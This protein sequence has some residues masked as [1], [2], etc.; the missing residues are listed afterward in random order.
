MDTS[1]NSSVD[2]T[3]TFRDYLRVLFRHKAVIAITFITVMVT[4]FI[5]LKLKT[6]VYEAQVKMLISAQKQVEAPY[7]RELGGYGKV[8]MALTQSEI[9]KSNPVIERSVK[10]LRLYGRPLDYEKNFCSPL[11]KRLVDWRTKTLEAKLE[12]LPT[13]QKQTLLFRKAVED[14]KAST[15]VA[16][17]RDTNLFTISVS[18]FSPVGS[19]IT[20][21]VVS[22]SYI[23]FDLEQQLAELQIK[24]GEKH[25]AVKQ[26][27]DNIEK[28]TAN[29]NGEPISAIE[30]IGPASVKIIEQA[31]VPI[32]PTGTPKL[33]TLVLAFFMSW[34]LGVMLAFGFEYMDHTF[35]SPQDVETFLN[36]PLLGSI[37]KKK[38]K[39]KRLVQDAKVITPYTS[40]YQTISDQIQ[41]LIKEK[42]LKSI[43]MTSALEQEGTSTIIANLGIC[44]THKAGCKVLIIDANLRNPSMHTAFKVSNNQGLSDILEGKSSFEEAVKAVDIY[45]IRD[46]S[47]AVRENSCLNV[48]TAGSTGL[49]PITLLDSSK[50]VDVIKKAGK[51]YEIILI[52]CTNL[53]NFRDASAISSL[54]DGIVLVVNE[55]KTRRQVVKSALIPLEKKKANLIGVILNN[56]TFPIPKGIYNRV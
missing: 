15:E 42:N 48:L 39:E 11:K 12:T 31:Q 32:K 40:S 34:F 16:P 9:V 5:G 24:Y 23:I 2:T 43:L 36:L 54:N 22:R 19:A 18:D 28:M 46:N 51:K 47:S 8:E 49:N 20:A 25:L 37:P 53:R 21:N 35:K 3:T 17:I 6:P 50:M 44:L 4:V 33:L 7:Y 52:D 29:L 13:Q 10:A 38:V 45:P 30:A 27:K 56:R 26:L 14:L 55:G 1:P 41:L